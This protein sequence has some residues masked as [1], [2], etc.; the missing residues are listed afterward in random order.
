MRSPGEEVWLELSGDWALD[1]ST[2]RGLK[3]NEDPE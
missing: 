3:D 1:V 2:F